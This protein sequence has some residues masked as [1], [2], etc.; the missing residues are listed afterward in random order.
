MK[1][2]IIYV[3]AAVIVVFAASAAV[4]PLRQRAREVAADLKLISADT[5]DVMASATYQRFAARREAVARMKATLKSI[6]AA[7]SVFIADSG[8]PTTSFI[9]RYAF[10]NDKSN[11]GP[12]VEIHR[13]RWVAKTG[14]IHSSISCT[15]TAMVDPATFDSIIW[16]YQVGEPVCAGWAAESTALANAP[17]PINPAP[18]SAPEPAPQPQSPAEPLR[19]PRHHRDWGPVNNTPPPMPYIVKDACGGEGCVRSGTWAACSDVVALRE[20]RL[21]AAVAFMIQARERFTALTTDIHVEVPGMVAFRHAT[22]NPVRSEGDE[23]D[24][25]AFTPADT[26]YLLNSMGEGYLMWWFRGQ[27]GVG[28]QFWPTDTAVLLRQTKTV[29]WIRARN[30]DGQEGWIVFDYR[31]MATGAYTDDIDRCLHPTK[32]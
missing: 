25:I 3:V 5:G 18:E 8:R 2:T 30:T 27:A 29:Y 21:G 24:S 19:P 11:F 12:F 17:V 28:Y 20:K 7:E 13:D 26:L 4:R 22:S 9:G 23:L 1:R 10:V 32:R 16:R 31:K 15:L 14:N 6:A